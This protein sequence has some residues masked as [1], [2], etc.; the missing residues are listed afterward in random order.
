MALVTGVEI[1]EGDAYMNLPEPM[2]PNFSALMSDIEKGTIK[3]PQFQRDFVWSKERSARLLDSIVK[4]YPIGTFILWKTKEE[5]RSIRDLGGLKLPETPAGDFINYVLDGQQRLTSLFAAFKGLK[6]QREEEHEVD[7]AEFYLDLEAGESDEIVLTERSERDQHSVIKL[8]DL[9]YGKLKTLTKFPE[10][11]QDRIQQYKDRISAYPFS[12]ILIREAPIDVAT[13]IFTRLNVGGKQLSVFEIMVAK[14]Y[15][16]KLNFDLAEK[17]DQLLK[18]LAE[19]G[20]D[21]VSETVFLQTVSMLLVKK[22]DKKNILTLKRADVIDMWPKAVDAVERA[23]D[24]FRGSFRIPVSKLLPYPG[25]LVPFAYFFYKHPD[26]PTGDLQRYLQDF[27]WR[28]SLGGRYSQ[29][30]EGRLAEDIRKIDQ[31]LAGNLPSYEW[32]VDTSARF[33]E[34]NGWFSVGRSYIKALL[35]ILAYHEPKSFNDNAVVHISND[36]LKQA[37]SRNYHHFFPWAFLEKQRV[38]P[39]RINHIANITIVDDFLNKREI[40]AK[41]PSQYMKKFRSENEDIDGCMRSHLIKLDEF[42][43]NDDDF[44]TFFRKRSALLSQELKKRIIEQGTDA[45]LAVITA[46]QTAE[47][48][49]LV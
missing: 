11:L 40:R 10:P 41:A 26:K 19:V 35:C 39:H 33:L 16:S 20:Y 43:V 38:G 5:L 42:G 21:T 8:C 17:C 14:T 45:K 30:M 37:N 13:E 25:L 4:G 12:T 29:G 3:I 15:D 1:P 49:A 28:A 23:V 34:E 18:D 48:E 9:L 31:I 47:E 46:D 36:W 32:A 27:F 6:I 24:F 44:D 7:Y 2:S 22:C